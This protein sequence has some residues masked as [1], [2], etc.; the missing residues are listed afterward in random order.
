M[1]TWQ[2]IWFV[3]GMPLAGLLAGLGTFI[4]IRLDERP[5]RRK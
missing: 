1:W 3:T 4:I 5:K 2:Q